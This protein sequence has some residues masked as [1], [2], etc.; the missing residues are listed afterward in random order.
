MG[1]LP[2]TVPP[3]AS[4]DSPR[5][6]FIG[7]GYPGTTHAACFAALGHQVLGL[8]R[9][10]AKVAKLNGGELPL[11]EPR[12]EELVRAELASGRLRFTSSYAEA[13]DFGDAH[14]LCVGTPQQRH[15]PAADLRY[16][17]DAV[18]SLAPRLR[19]QSLVIG[20]STVPVGTADRIRDLVAELSPEPDLVDVVW[21]PEFL[22]GPRSRGRAETG[23][24]RVR[25]QWLGGVGRAAHRV[26]GGV[27]PGRLRRP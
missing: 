11:R 10:E 26:S 14:F 19:R 9:D 15:G 21:S 13:A 17:D 4:C 5:L 6:V 7:T 16:L 3:L 8:D 22:R 27:R 2:A 23:A 1:D 18:R 25:H 20:K 24:A 12:L